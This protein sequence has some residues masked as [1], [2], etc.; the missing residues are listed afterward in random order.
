MVRVGIVGCGKIADAFH[1]PAWRQVRGGG[2]VAV[3]DTRKGVA[4]AFADAHG[5]DDAFD[6]LDTMLD[7][8]DID[9]VDICTPHRQH[10]DQAIAA[11]ERGLHVIVEKPMAPTPA[12]CTRMIDAATATGSVLMCAQHQRFRPQAD[13]AR[14]LCDNGEL[15]KIYWAKA[16]ILQQRSVPR[17]SGNTFTDVSLS[18]GGPLLD[19]GAHM[20]DLAWWLMDTPQPIAASGATFRK[21]APDAGKTAPTGASWT[22][23]DVEDLAVGQLRFDNGAILSVEASY[24]LNTAAETFTCELFGTVGGL[25]FPDMTFVSGGTESVTVETLV[26]QSDELASV[27]ELQHFIDL[28]AGTAEPRVPATQT[29]TVI[30]MID[31]LYQSAHEGREIR[32]EPQDLS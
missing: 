29:R 11:L 18:G 19:Q 15:G 32:I 1:A 9:A 25:R 8:G 21:L 10:P 13:V 24:L 14:T 17:Q 7:A 2:V 3:C 31:A 5:I 27:R 22:R 16:S 4:R 30:A 26:P 6:S 20:V 28:T 12:D 23:F